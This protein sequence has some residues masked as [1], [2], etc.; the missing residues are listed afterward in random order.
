MKIVVAT[1]N[2]HKLRELR[3]LLKHFDVQLYSLADF[4]DCPSVPEDGK[5]FAENALKK[6]QAVCMHT[7]LLTIADDSGLEVDFL[8]GQ[9]GVFSAR[10]AGHGADDTKNYEKLLRELEGVMP[11]KRGAR[12]R[13]ALAVAAPSGQYRIVEGEYCGFITTQPRGTNG[14]GYD[15]VFLDPASGL[16]F[17][18]MPPEQKNQIS[19]RARAL[20]AL[21]KIFP[22]FLNA[23]STGQHQP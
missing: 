19:H 2:Q 6:A 7:G 5:S 12:F 9:P 13:C 3:E 15:P 14:F 8:D 4:P 16:T 18:E 23:A 11:E 21:V 1:T 10:Y 22:D 17:A 20:Q